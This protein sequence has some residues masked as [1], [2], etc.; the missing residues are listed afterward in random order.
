MLRRKTM[1]S[2][3]K[4]LVVSFV[5]AQT[6]ACFS[7]HVDT[8]GLHEDC[9]IPPGAEGPGRAVVTIAGFDFAPDT[10]RV[11]ANTTVTWV[12]CDK[13]A[14]TESHTSTSDTGVWSSPEF[15]EGE[16]YVRLFASSG[17]FPYHCIP[18]PTMTGVIIVQ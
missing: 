13:A 8:T 4:L 6:G 16:T 17:S 2:I 5:T 14:G 11:A 9:N 3:A 1:E 7:E 12:N 18:H 15:A 10:L